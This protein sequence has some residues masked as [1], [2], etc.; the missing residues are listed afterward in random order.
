M[1]IFGIIIFLG[2]ACELAQREMKYDHAWMEN[3][4]QRFLDKIY[5]KLSHV[6]RNGDP[7]QTYPGCVNLSFA[8]VE[9]KNY[10]FNILKLQKYNFNYI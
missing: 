5:S 6:I 3:L 8:Y 9:G 4:S 7:E 2:A 10:F 1:L